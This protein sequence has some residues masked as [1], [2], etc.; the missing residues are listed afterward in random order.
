MS[1]LKIGTSVRLSN[2]ETAVVKSRLAS[3]GQGVIYLVK[4][5]MKKMALK[6]YLRHPGKAFLKNLMDNVRRGA[7]APNFIWPLAVTEEVMGSFGYVMELRPKGYEDM[8]RFILLK[9]KFADVHAQLNACLQICTA[10]QKL[11]IHGLSYQDMNDGNF[12]IDPKTGD[13]LICDNDNVAPDKTSMGVLG[14]AGYMAP[15]IVEGVSM[16]DRYTDY[17]SLAVCLFILIYMNRPFEGAWNLSCPCDNNP[18]MARLLFGFGSVFIMDPNDRKNRPVPGM[19][20]NVI[21][22]WNVYPS[23]LGRAFCKTFSAEAIKDPTQRL[24]DK[25]WYNILLQVRSMLARCPH[26]GNET[27]VDVLSPDPC[28]VYCQKPIVVSSLKVGR[29]TLPLLERQPIWACQISSEQDMNVKAGEVVLKRGIMGMKNISHTPW[30]VILPD[31]SVKIIN[32]GDSFPVHKGLKIRFGQGET[33]E[34]I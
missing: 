9:A 28:C 22:R 15:E 16:P 7:P 5:G 8:S 10:F 1:G 25:Q 18:E 12:F 27:F 11:H 17:H 20:N 29:F 4:V 21:R 26:C 3:G 13:V 32:K 6:W 19:H 23:F 31:S 2:G 33:G 34:V 24:M 30:T 14:K